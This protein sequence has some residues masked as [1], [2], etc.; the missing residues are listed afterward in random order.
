RVLVG[1]PPPFLRLRAAPE[2]A[3]LEDLCLGPAGTLSVKA[4]EQGRMRGEV[5]IDQRRDLVR[6]LVREGHHDSSGAASARRANSISVG[7]VSGSWLSV[8][9]GPTSA[10]PIAPTRAAAT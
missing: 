2:Q 4:F 8:A 7:T 5:A 10:S 1:Q 9:S 3:E 6:H